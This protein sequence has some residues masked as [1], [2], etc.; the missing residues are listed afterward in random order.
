MPDTE[1]IRLRRW[2]LTASGSPTADLNAVASFLAGRALSQLRLLRTGSNLVFA[3]PE[4]R[5][6]LRVQVPSHEEAVRA[7]LQR[8]TALLAEDAPIVGPAFPSIAVTGEA[9]V[10]QWRLGDAIGINAHASLGHALRGLHQVDSAS[11]ELPVLQIESKVRHRLANL[12]PDIPASLVDSLRDHAENALALFRQMP[13]DRP[14]VLHGDAHVGN[15]VMM[16]GRPLLI[17]LD[18]LCIGSR[19]FDLLPTYVSFKRFHG[20]SSKWEAF[21][22]GYG[23]A[24]WE[25]LDSLS[26]IRETTMNAWLADL[27]NL[28]EAARLELRHRIATW[29]ATDHK[30]WTAL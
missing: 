10:T 8:V 2:G 12:D 18:D 20:D 19:E 24:D 7:N 13:T 11:L 14:L 29:D 4:A 30:A 27:W 26:V 3:D 1:R 22:Q 15:L 25:R 16:D 5:V 6:V 23:D 28:S 21:Q 17:D 9:V